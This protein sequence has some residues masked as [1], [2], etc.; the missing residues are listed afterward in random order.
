MKNRSG[1]GRLEF[2]I[3]V[4]L[5]VLGVFTFASPGAAL[6]GFAVAYGVIAVVMGVADIV[7][8]VRAERY[9]GFGPIV[10]LVAGILSVMS[11]VMLLIYPGAGRLVLSLLFPIWFIAHCISRLSQLHVIR[12][13]AGNAMYYFTL[14]VNIIGLILGFLM[15]FQPILTLLSASYIAGM[16]LILLGVDGIAIAFS[17]IGSRR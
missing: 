3:G 13:M 7:L 4:I 8:Y 9:T 17:G 2:I 5:I 10:A 11:G 15:L 6:T 12:V 1:F 16:Y 14:V